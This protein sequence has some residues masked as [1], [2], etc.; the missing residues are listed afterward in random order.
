MPMM[1]DPRTP[2]TKL[3]T[4]GSKDAVVDED[5]QRTLVRLLL[6][7]LKSVLMRHYGGEEMR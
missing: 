2:E 7:R 6:T 3:K 5:E 4:I 1:R